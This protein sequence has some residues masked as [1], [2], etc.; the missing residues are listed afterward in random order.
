MELVEKLDL[1]SEVAS[2][3]QMQAEQA[4]EL[5]ALGF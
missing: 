3:A 2:Q 1:H 5:E 4:A